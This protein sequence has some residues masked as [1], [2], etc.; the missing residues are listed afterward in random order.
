LN[1]DHPLPKSMEQQP[2]SSTCQDG[3]PNKIK[4]CKPT[5]NATN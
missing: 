4:W 2:S 3:V 1:D 5:I